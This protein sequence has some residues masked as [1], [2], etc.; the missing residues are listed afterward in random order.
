MGHEDEGARVLEE[1]LLEPLYGLDVE[2]VGRLVEEQ[3]LRAW[4]QGAG[5]RSLF[6]HA[7]RHLGHR[8]RGIAEPELGAEGRVGELEALAARG[9]ILRRGHRAPRFRRHSRDRRRAAF[10]PAGAPTG[11]SPADEE[12]REALAGVEGGTLLEQAH[13]EMRA[14]AR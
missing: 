8:R 5:D 10:C 6:D 13:A 14:F 4:G 11:G 12:G 7:A 1:P 3:E 9:S 2:V